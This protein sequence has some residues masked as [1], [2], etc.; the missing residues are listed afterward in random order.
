MLQDPHKPHY[1]QPEEGQQP[2]SVGLTAQPARSVHA[3]RRTNLH[4]LLQAFS[5]EQMAA[6]Q[7]A[8]GLEVAFAAKLQVSASMLSQ[9]KRNRNISDA[10]AKQIERICKKP[11]GWMSA[12]HSPDACPI[13]DMDEVQ[14]LE[15]ARKAWRQ[16]S[17]EERQRLSAILLP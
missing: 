9:I 10:L 3:L 7:P 15:L 5:L 4:T 14:F 8:K 6:G 12:T 1:S 13:Q 11:D 17:P 16:S 2:L